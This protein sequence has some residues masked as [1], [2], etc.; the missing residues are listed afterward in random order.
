VRDDKTNRIYLQH[1]EPIRFGAENEKGVRQRDDGSVEVVELGADGDSE[2]LLVHDAKHAE[3][4]L[5]FALSR[6][7]ASTVGAA[8]I[9]IFRS[10]ERPVYDDLMA[11]QL[12][13]A[14]E[15]KGAGD[16]EKLLLAGDTWRIS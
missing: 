5:A 11:E 3:P 1:G 16:L 15:K 7:T 14:R 13:K 10:V 12:E 9:G 2:G 4:S 8:P 6:L